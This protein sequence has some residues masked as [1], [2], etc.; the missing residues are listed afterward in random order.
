[1]THAHEVNV[2]LSQAAKGDSAKCDV[3][4]RAKPGGLNLIVVVLFP[5]Y[6]EIE[7]HFVFISIEK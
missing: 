6:N 7:T 3:H 4:T 1:M 5:M 2:H